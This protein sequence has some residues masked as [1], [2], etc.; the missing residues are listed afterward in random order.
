MSRLRR[1]TPVV[2]LGAG[3][4]V[5]VKREVARYAWRAAA[6]R[7]RA[8]GAADPDVLRREF[9]VDREWRRT[10]GGYAPRLDART[11]I[12]M[13]RVHGPWAEVDPLTVH[14]GWRR[15]WAAVGLFV[16]AAAVGVQGWRGWRRGTGPL[17]GLHPRDLDR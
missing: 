13:D 11:T 2:E 1:G 12:A 16:W 5:G 8:K 6:R 4:D 7:T 9:T 10:V 3:A 15:P 14:D 17:A